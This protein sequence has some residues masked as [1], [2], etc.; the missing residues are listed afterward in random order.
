MGSASEAEWFLPIPEAVSLCSPHSHL[1]RVVLAGSRQIFLNFTVCGFTL[2]F[3]EYVSYVICSYPYCYWLLLK[4]N[5]IS[6]P[7]EYIITFL[8]TGHKIFFI[9]ACNGKCLSKVKEVRNSRLP[10][11]IHSFLVLEKEKTKKTD[12][13]SVIAEN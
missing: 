3:L 5:L 12:N 9:V 7:G 1:C 6:L 4:N 11:L 10:V 8:Y 2:N 13:M